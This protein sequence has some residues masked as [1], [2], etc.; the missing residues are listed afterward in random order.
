MSRKARCKSSTGVY[1]VII[2]GADRR[3]IFAD[4]EDCIRF[5]KVLFRV[6]KETDFKMYAYCLMGNH[7][8]FLIKELDVPLEIIF[9]KIGCSYVYYYNRKYQLHGHLFQDRYKSESVETWSYFMNVIRYICQNPL[10]ANICQ[11][12]FEYPWT[13]CC[14]IMDQ[15]NMLDSFDEYQFMDKDELRD[16]V[17]R[18]SDVECMEDMPPKRLTDQEAIEKIC[19][20]CMCSH[21]QE[22]GGW[23]IEQ[24][25]QAIVLAIKAG[26]SIRQFSRLTAISKTTV[27]RVVRG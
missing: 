22:I 3:V 27:E 23:K 25:N 7:A 11:N 9:K 1:H 17:V 8:H 14:K 12:L 26:V 6:K 18:P 5:L 24:R 21:V 2:R 20:I 4:D 16:F 10:K 19:K 15:Q 13:G